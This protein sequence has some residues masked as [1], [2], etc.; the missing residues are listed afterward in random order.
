HRDLELLDVGTGA[1]RTVVT[2]AEVRA[3]YPMEVA[4]HFGDRPISIFFPILSPDH[5][6]VIFK[7]A[8]PA[9][10]DFRSKDAS[11]REGLVCYDLRA[12][13]LLWMRGKWGHPAWHPDSGSVINVDG[14]G[15]YVID[16]A[17]GATRRPQGLPAFPGSHPSFSRQG[18]L[19]A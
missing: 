18:S 11:D 2:A 12:G 17:T 6:K 10:G 3:A 15:L 8:T 5:G 1:I 19:F 4:Q 7:L 9:A 14:K 13:K 16:A